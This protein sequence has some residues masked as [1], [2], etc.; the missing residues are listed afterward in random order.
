MSAVRDALAVAV[1]LASRAA[2]SVLWNT[3]AIAVLKVDL[4]TATVA[5][6]GYALST[7]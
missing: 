6:L 7:T 1:L 3:G 2:L 5:I 4:V